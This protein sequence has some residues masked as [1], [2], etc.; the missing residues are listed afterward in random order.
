[1]KILSWSRF[2][3]GKVARYLEGFFTFSQRPMCFLVFVFADLR[4]LCD[5]RFPAFVGCTGQMVHVV[6]V[7]A[8][9][10]LWL[11]I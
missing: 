8:L 5:H 10:M 6:V 2:V 9:L 7:D 3:D 1:L 4:T 11:R